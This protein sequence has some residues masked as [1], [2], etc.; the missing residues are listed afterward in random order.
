[1]PIRHLRRLY[2]DPMMADG[3]WELIREQGRIMG[4]ASRSK[5]QPIKIAGFTAEQEGFE[6]AA[7]YSEWRFMSLP[8]GAA[9]AP[10]VAPKPGGG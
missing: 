1:M 3:Q 4:V 8:G 10:G 2:R 9:P 6:G 7:K 5:D